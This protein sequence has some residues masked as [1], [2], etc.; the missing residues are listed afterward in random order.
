V[1]MDA[2]DL[3]S[4]TINVSWSSMN[5]S[6]IYTLTIN[7]NT[8]Q[9]Q[10][11]NLNQTYHVFTA[12]EAAPPCEVYNFSVTTTYVGA[13]YTGAGCSVPSP[14][15]SRMLP[16]LPNVGPPIFTLK[17]QSTGITLNTSFEV[18]VLGFYVFFSYV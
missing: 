12:L 2:T 18:H 7:R 17:T 13:T 9:P 1:F 14:V 6:I 16:S 5:Q 8:D 3:H 10:T 4:Q 11:L 15:I